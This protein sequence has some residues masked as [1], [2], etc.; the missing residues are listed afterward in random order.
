MLIFY[1]KLKFYLVID[2]YLCR[3]YKKYEL[4]NILKHIFEDRSNIF[5]HLLHGAR[6]AKYPNLGRTPN[7]VVSRIEFSQPNP[8]LSHGLK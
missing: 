5:C 3:N 2:K 8:Y 4:F 6:W 7:L 1:D